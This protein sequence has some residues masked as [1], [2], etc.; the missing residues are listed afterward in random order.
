VHAVIPTL[1]WSAKRILSEFEAS[2]GYVARPRQ[3]REVT[4]FC[5]SPTPFLFSAALLDR[6]LGITSKYSKYNKNV[7]NYIICIFKKHNRITLCA[8]F[9]VLG[10]KPRASHVLNSQSTTEI[11]PQPLS[12]CF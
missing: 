6:S 8:F 5:S 9:K 11:C 4:T 1:G 10:I 12:Y 2:L 7:Y 3:K